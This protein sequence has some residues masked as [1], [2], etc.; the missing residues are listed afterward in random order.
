V[1]NKHTKP[2]FMTMACVLLVSSGALGQRAYLVVDRATGTA[3]AIS[4]ATVPVDGYTISSASGLL[5]V[6]GWNSIA[7]QGGAGWTEANPTPTLLTELTLEN[8]GLEAGEGVAIGSPFMPGM[9]AT[10]SQE[11]LAF[12]LSVPN[13]DPTQP[14]SIVDGYVVYT[15][16]S[17]VPTITVNRESGMVEL[18]NAGGFAVDGF[19]ISSANGF[20]NPTE[21]TAPAGFTP[22]NSTGNLVTGLNWEGSASFPATLNL[23]ALFSPVG[24]VPASSEDLTLEYTR[25]DSTEAF[26]GV[27][28]YTGAINDLVLQVNELT[29][30]AT[31]QQTSPNMPTLS[32]TGYSVLSASDGLDTGAWQKIGGDFTEASP[33]AG[34][35]AELNL[36][37]SMT[38]SNGTAHGLGS[39]FA[40]SSRDLVFEY[41]TPDVDKAFGS[42]EYV[43]GAGSSA[44]TCNDIAAS[45]AIAGDLNGDGS[46]GFPDFL[47]LSNNFTL[48]GVGY[49]GG[50]I[51]CDG[52]VGFPDFLVLSN[53][54][55]QPAGA[56]AASVPEPTSGMLAM[57]AMLTGFAFRRTRRL[58]S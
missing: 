12:Q 2:W 58:N 46:V 4:S 10:P 50:D 27:V 44:P 24:V 41:S 5:N 11:D 20:L 43:L 56:E 52:T 34:A 39:I 22:S 48:D 51:N 32:V 53:N 21:L 8:G 40:G 17:P 1:L 54:F 23:G 6:D 30:E 28:E 37:G 7:D 57:L 13:A 38:F 14:G 45:R 55:G 3:E 33:R 49:E 36:N 42:V 18:T 15:G 35:I 25:P 47:V 26:T 9:A 19:S 16:A 31:I 29:G